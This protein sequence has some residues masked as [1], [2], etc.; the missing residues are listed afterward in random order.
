M[1]NTTFK[2]PEVVKY[3]NENYYA[4]KFDAESNEKITFKG[5]TFQNPNFDPSRVGGR[6]GT[7][8]LT[9]AI[10]PVNGRVAYPTIV[11]MDEKFDIL[12][13]V[14]GMQQP[15]QIMP[16]LTYFGDDIY[17]SKSWQEYTGSGQ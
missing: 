6:N 9:M 2:D 15:A 12:S 11:Y 8:E 5:Q 4:I 3:I 16:I 13:P 1:N 7:H 14:Q 10:A 17:K